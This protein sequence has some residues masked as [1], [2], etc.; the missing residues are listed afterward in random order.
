VFRS[1]QDACSVKLK[2]KPWNIYSTTAFSHPGYET[3]LLQSFNN[4][5]ETE[6]ASLL[7][8]SIGGKKIQIMKFLTQRGLLHQASSYRTCGRRGTKEFLR[9]KKGPLNTCWR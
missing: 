2:K 9:R 4:L 8:S 5:I 1:L 3:Y 6:V 7:P